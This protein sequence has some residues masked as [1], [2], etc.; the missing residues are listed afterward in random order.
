TERIGSRNGNSPVFVCLSVTLGTNDHFGGK[1]Y[2]FRGTS[3]HFPGISD[4]CRGTKYQSRDTSEHFRGT[5]D[6][7][8]R[9]KY[10]SRGASDH[11]H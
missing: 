9:T 5:S 11:F 6:H 7:Y 1:K 2:Y 10:Q 8:R 4:H 3:D